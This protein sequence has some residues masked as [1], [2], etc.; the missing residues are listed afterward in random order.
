M[1]EL[2]VQYTRCGRYTVLPNRHALGVDVS[3]FLQAE[4]VASTAA[5]KRHFF[6][7]GLQ[8]TDPG[9]TA[10]IQRMRRSDRC[11]DGRNPNRTVD[12]FQDGHGTVF[13]PLLKTLTIKY[14]LHWP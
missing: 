7:R 14:L 3:L 11:S 5:A 12:R 9:L 1:S 8:D 10:L 13:C 4:K 6:I 2:S